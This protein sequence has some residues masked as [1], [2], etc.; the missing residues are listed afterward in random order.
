LKQ[1]KNDRGLLLNRPFA[2]KTKKRKGIPRNRKGRKH[3]GVNLPKRG[4]VRDS[5]PENELGTFSRFIV[6]R[7]L[8]I[9]RWAVTFQRAQKA[10]KIQT[11]KP[12]LFYHRDW[13]E[14]GRGRK[15]EE[16][17]DIKVRI[18]NKQLKKGRDV[19]AETGLVGERKRCW[20]DGADRR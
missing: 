7:A 12:S 3:K 14:H 11:N 8:T 18:R 19:I 1:R 16:V 17:C 13:E 5:G 2:E 15:R 20:E 4:K 10:K 9:I 6:D